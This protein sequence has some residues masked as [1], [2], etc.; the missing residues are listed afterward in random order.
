MPDLASQPAAPRQFPCKHC[1]AS[2]TFAPGTHAL[3]CPYCGTLNE[4]AAD[5]T[6]IEELNYATQLQQLE[7]QHDQIEA[8]VVH[9]DG[10][11][12][13]STL[14]P[15]TTAG[16]CPFCGR[17]IVATAQTKCII[18]P[19]S[20]LAFAI[21]RQKATPQFSAWLGGL[22]FAPN[23]LKNAAETGKLVGIYL[24]AWT[25][26]CQ[27]TSAYTGERGDH[28]WETETYTETVNGRSETRTRQVQKTRWWSASGVVQVPFDDVLVLADRS[29]PD[30]LRAKL[31]GWDL[32]A[33]VPYADEYLSGFVA[34]TYQVS[35][36]DGF[37][38][39]K[40]IMD[41][42]IRSAIRH[43]I[44]G[45]EQ[46]ISSVNTQYFGVTFK[47]VLLPIWMSAYR[48]KGQ[49]YHFVINGRTGRVFGERPYSAAKIVMTILVI[50]AAILIVMGIVGLMKQ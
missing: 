35:L 1:G 41:G 37:E 26:D 45:D 36:P 22:W 34:E 15:G 11:G 38:V 10:C 43:D 13:E 47:H 29:L 33:L 49:T 46:R 14:P 40:G 17:A 48:F 31:N 39:A 18:K 28:Y 4:I 8:V 30:R 12:A 6:P 19:R 3:K 2:L 24:P 9:C 44:G 23:S 5:A 50:L 16:T 27:T 21:D 32:P 20:L 42:E 25:Y 7:T